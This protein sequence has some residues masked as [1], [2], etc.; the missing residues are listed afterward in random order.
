MKESKQLEKNMVKVNKENRSKS[1]TGIKK[2]KKLDSKQSMGLLDNM[3]TSSFETNPS[4]KRLRF[5]S[6][7][8]AEGTIEVDPS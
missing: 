4:N 8:P 2:S 3:P 7:D 5:F 1:K 6:P